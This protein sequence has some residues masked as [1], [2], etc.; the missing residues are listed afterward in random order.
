MMGN[1]CKYQSERT[2]PNM[3]PQYDAVIVEVFNMGK[4]SHIVHRLEKKI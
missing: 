4:T 1:L 2:D 3:R